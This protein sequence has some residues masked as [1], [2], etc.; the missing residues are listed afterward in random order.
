MVYCGKFA[1]L[2]Y[3]TLCF[4][5]NPLSKQYGHMKSADEQG[6]IQVTARPLSNV[7]C[8]IFDLKI[9][10]CDIKVSRLGKQRIRAVYKRT[11]NL[12][13]AAFVFHFGI[14]KK[15]SFTL[16]KEKPE[17]TID[18]IKKQLDKKKQYLS[19][20]THYIY[21]KM[22]AKSLKNVEMNLESNKCSFFVE[23]EKPTPSLGR[24]NR[25]VNEAK[26][27]TVNAAKSVNNDL[28]KP[29]VDLEYRWYC[30]DTVGFCAGRDLGSRST[31]TVDKKYAI[32]GANFTFLLEARTQYS[33]WQQFKQFIHVNPSRPYSINCIGKCGKEPNKLNTLER[34]QLFAECEFHCKLYENKKVSG[35]IRHDG[36]KTSNTRIPQFALGPKILG[37]IPANTRFK[38]IAYYNGNESN[39][40]GEQ[41]F[42]TYPIPRLE[43]CKSIPRSGTPFTKFKMEC[44]YEKD[45]VMNFEVQVKSNNVVVYSTTAETLDTIEFVIPSR[46]TVTVKLRD[47]NE[48]YISQKV[49]VQIDPLVSNT[50]NI[51]EVGKI[52]NDVFEGKNA[53]SKSV[54]ELIEDGDFNGAVQVINVMARELTNFPIGSEDGNDL[55]TNVTKKLLNS[56]TK[57]VVNDIEMVKSVS[58]IISLI[59]HQA[60]NHSDSNT[61]MKFGKLCNNIAKQQ[62]YLLENDIEN[63][64]RERDVVSVT[65]NLL[66]C[67]GS[68]IAPYYEIFKKFSAEIEITTE[69]PVRDDLSENNIEEY[70]EYVADD[71]I[72]EQMNNYV[73]AAEYIVDICR[74]VGKSLILASSLYNELPT[75]VERQDTI[76]AVF[77]ATGTK[78]AGAKF[79]PHDVKVTVSSVME[80]NDSLFSVRICSYKNNP[81]WSSSKTFKIDTNVIDLSISDLATETEIEDF[82]TQPMRIA[83]RVNQDIAGKEIIVSVDFSKQTTS[84]HA[85]DNFII[86]IFKAKAME[87]FFI[88][89]FDLDEL[90]SISAVLVD[91]ERPLLHHFS[92]AH[93]IT[94]SNNRLFIQNQVRE[95]KWFLLGLRRETDVVVQTYIF[96]ISIYTIKCLTWNYHTSSWQVACT[97]NEMTNNEVIHCECLHFSTIAGALEYN[98]RRKEVS[99]FASLFALLLDFISPYSF[100]PFRKG[101]P[102][103]TKFISSSDIPAD[104]RYGY[105]ISTSTGSKVDAGTTSDIVIQI[106][107]TNGKSQAHVLNFP[108]PFIELLQRSHNDMFVLATS[109]DLG[110]LLKIYLWFDCTGTSPNWFC[111]ELKICD[112]Q[113]KIWYRFKVNK[114]LRI[115]GTPRLFLDIP[116]ETIRQQFTSKQIMKNW[117]LEVLWK[118]GPLANSL[119]RP[120]SNSEDPSFELPKRLS[121]ILSI[122][123]SIM[124]LLLYFYGIPEMTPRDAITPECYYK[125]DWKT[126]NFGIYAAVI[127]FFPHTAVMGIFKK[128]RLQYDTRTNKECTYFFTL[129]CWGIL[130]FNIIAQ[131]HLLL[132]YG[133]WFISPTTWQWSTSLL[134]AILFYIFILDYTYNILMFCVGNAIKDGKVNLKNIL[135]NV[136]HQRRYLY[137]RFGR[138]ICRPILTPVYHV[139]SKTEYLKKHMFFRQK[140]EVLWEIQDLMMIILFLFF[141]YVIILQEKNNTYDVLGH[142]EAQLLLKGHENLKK[143]LSRV[144][145][146]DEFEDFMESIFIPTLQSYQWYGRYVSVTPGLTTDV[147]NRYLGI[148]RLRQLRS[149][150]IPCTISKLMQ[151]INR[152]CTSTQY[153]TNFDYL[154]YTPAWTDA[155]P[156]YHRSRLGYVWGYQDSTGQSYV[157]VSGH[158]R[159]GGYIALLG[160]NMK[161]SLVNLEYLKR[162][163]WMN[164]L[165]RVIF[166]E[167]PLYNV[168]TNL[169]NFATVMLEKTPTGYIHKKTI[170]RSVRVL[171]EGSSST[172]LSMIFTV[173]FMVLIVIITVRTTQRIIRTKV[174]YGRDLWHFSDVAIVVM[175]MAWI[176]MYFQKVISLKNFVKELEEKRSNTFVDY[177]DLLSAEAWITVLASALICV[178]TVRIWRLLRFAKVFRVVERTLTYSFESMIYCFVFFLIFCI[179]FGIM[180]FV[181]FCTT[182]EQFRDGIST[183]KSLILMTI[184]VR[185]PNTLHLDER[186]IR[187]GYLY[188]TMFYTVAY[189]FTTIFIA[190]IIVN[191][192]IAQQFSFEEKIEYDIREYTKDQKKNFGRLARMW[193]RK[194][195]LRAGKNQEKEEDELVTPK[196]NHI[197]YMNC[198]STSSTKMRAMESVAKCYILRR[199]KGLM[200]DESDQAEMM[201]TVRNLC[202]MK[203]GGDEIFFTQYMNTGDCRLVDNR[204]LL[205]V[206]DVVKRMLESP[207]KRAARLKITEE[208][209]SLMAE[210]MAKLEMMNY[211]LKTMLK[212]VEEIS[213]QII[214]R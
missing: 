177:F 104:N 29:N 108:D 157:G 67:G 12:R 18:E 90:D 103:K 214:H 191:F 179:G 54:D 194:F 198:V 167:F 40:V 79:H 45:Q 211:R 147:C 154:N 27:F 196:S 46:S 186:E 195:R 57:L 58:G 178:I 53:G 116:V 39:I 155:I 26:T 93:K 94:K 1:L 21:V 193:V 63:N 36:K 25:N 95:D 132:I 206:E 34:I 50:S 197:R 135:K 151:F 171:K 123:L 47:I 83:F 153:A 164:I 24:T 124:M 92:I 107:G 183:G 33:E 114:W 102:R 208:N 176:I 100:I 137:S 87:A 128:S 66:S 81:F 180:G 205:M 22:I 204:R 72:D 115:D 146:I 152:S 32:S 207:E 212:V 42:D 158:Y 110:S 77:K 55:M 134:I 6:S 76:V 65:R 7:E 159:K 143:S 148:I 49:E 85:E 165:T 199:K 48:V 4:A 62:V 131:I 136:E 187:F 133:Y 127:T 13:E 173:L 98:D 188:V 202:E 56:L 161:N 73:A 118:S 5:L 149:E 201:K 138:S 117:L 11:C 160:R 170:V 89:F 129:L 121:L 43:N 140:R 59:A 82:G 119:F 192:L 101:S 105:L 172:A 141:Q 38:V 23:R 144:N 30:N 31:V 182:S 203:K 69:Y 142:T 139:M 163:S 2:S 181:L 145:E 74:N 174:W 19:T 20:G 10:D 109:K 168:N 3:W 75:Y 175:S 51:S 41:E 189:F 88:E 64:I 184:G 185:G 68:Q 112:L 106:F 84:N 166:I 17:I 120:T 15:Y 156:E 96:K 111:D 37:S 113:R 99:T 44:S 130:I 80:K 97:I 200:I 169:F 125:L 209:E 213:I 70:P 9:S 16:S 91:M 150:F 162:Y 14:E 78:I 61:A 35:L 8:K 86:F 52:L 28:G 71:L 122:L 190:I 60:K 210:N 126:V